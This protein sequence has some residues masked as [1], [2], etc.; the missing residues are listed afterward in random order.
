VFGW[1]SHDRPTGDSC[2]DDGHADDGRADDLCADDGHTDDGRADDSCADDGHTDDGRAD[3]SCADDHNADVLA[4][5]EPD[6]GSHATAGSGYAH[7]DGS[8]HQLR[9]A[10]ALACSPRRAHMICVCTHIY[11][12]HS[13]GTQRAGGYS[14][15]TQLVSVY[16]RGT[17][18]VSVAVYSRGTDSSAVC[19][20]LTAY[21][22]AHACAA[23]YVL[24]PANTN[25]CLAGSAKI[26]DVTA[27]PAAAAALGNTYAGSVSQAQRPSGCYLDTGDGRVYFNPS[28][29]GAAA[30]GAQPLCRVTGA[31]FQP[32]P[33]H[34]YGVALGRV[35]GRVPWQR[36]LPR[37]YSASAEYP[38][39]T[40][41]VPR[42]AHCVCV[43]RRHYRRADDSCADDG[44]T[45]DYR[46]NDSYTDDGRADDAHTVYS[47]ADDS[48][49]DDA[50]TDDGR[51]DGRRC[52]GAGSAGE[53]VLV[54]A[55]RYSRVLWSP[56]DRRNRRGSGTRTTLGT[57]EGWAWV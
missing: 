28:A 19:V 11:Q 36:P 5:A 37:E 44:H 9:T 18:R 56:Y 27:C 22:L 21:A 54:R 4:L 14:R 35:P 31:P 26:T 46:P 32:P 30:A 15:G 57:L 20:L 45:S 33:P 16:S 52:V 3:D 38:V 7:R 50:R 41:C 23:D 25:A 12:G 49:S 48:C 10:R 34:T 43:W 51:A 1:C 2:P 55:Q 13:R 42:T 39:S 53:R 8:K 40:A 17:Q 6:D 24:G 47:R 29:P